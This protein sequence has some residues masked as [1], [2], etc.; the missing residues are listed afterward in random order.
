MHPKTTDTL[1][2]FMDG[3]IPKYITSKKSLVRMVLWTALYAWLFIS[4]Y[5]PFNSRSWVAGITELTYFLFATLAVLVAM[6]LVSVSRVGMYYYAKRHDLT[7]VEYGFWVAGEI[8]GMSL[9]Y[10]LTPVLFMDHVPDKFFSLWGDAAIYTSFILLIPYAIV[11]LAL[12]MLHYK[13]QL[14][15]AGIQVKAQQGQPASMPDMLNFYDERGEL[16]L[17]LRPESLFYIEAADNYVQIHFWKG[18]KLQ[19]YLLRTTLREVEEQFKDKDLLRCHRSFVVN[20][21]RVKMLKRTS[22]G[23]ELDFDTENVPN[24]PVTKTYAEKVMRRFSEEKPSDN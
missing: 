21:N 16:K 3:I 7:Y 13:Q 4:I 2:F 19:H 24:L 22:D 8:M 20:I 5:Q 15:A 17:S 6:L 10:A 9:V 11:M 23:L 12:I 1:L 14:E 18:D